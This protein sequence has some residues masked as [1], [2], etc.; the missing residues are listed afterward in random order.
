VEA[1]T[2]RAWDEMRKHCIDST[3]FGICENRSGRLRAAVSRRPSLTL[4]ALVQRR[5]FGP[6]R[7]PRCQLPANQAVTIEIED[8]LR[9]G[10]CRAA[11]ATRNWHLV[12]S[13]VRR[14]NR[15]VPICRDL[16]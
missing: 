7:N 3:H 4:D 2:T 8:L 9:A 1:L 12:T 15:K 5:V 13:E 16:G 6:W 11:P 14:P 10:D